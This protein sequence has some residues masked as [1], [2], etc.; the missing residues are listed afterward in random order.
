MG[1]AFFSILGGKMAFLEEESE[2]ERIK[3]CFWKPDTREKKAVCF[4][5]KGIFY[6]NTIAPTGDL[7]YK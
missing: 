2:P 4:V 1:P 6:E 5:L 3:R 7:Y